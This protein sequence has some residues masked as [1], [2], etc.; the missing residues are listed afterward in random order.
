V[1]WQLKGL[2][3][4]SEFIKLWIGQTVSN[5]GSGITGVALPLT[6]V[7]YLA[8]TPAQMGI[9]SALSDVPVIV[10]GLLAGVWVDRLRRRAILISADLGRAILFGSIPI[11]ALF[12]VLHLAHLYIVAFLAG[13]LTVFFNVADISYLPTLV[14][15]EELVEANSKLGISDSLAEISGPAVA[16]PLAQL[17]GAPFALAFDALSYLLSALSIGLIRFAEPQPLVEERQSL[18]RESLKGLRFLFGNSLLRTLAISASIFNFFGSFIGT[19]YILYIVRE[20]HITPAII[21][22]L[23]ATGGV[24]AL[25]GTFIAQRVIRRIGP[26]RSIGVMLFLYGMTGL[27]TPLA[28]GPV[29][30]AAIMLFAAQLGDASVA[31]YFIAEISLRQSLIPNDLSGRLHAGMQFLTQGSRPISAIL[32][33]ILGTLIGLRLTILIGVVGVI[34]AGLWLLLSPIRRVSSL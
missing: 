4:N 34:C 30:L 15:Q 12:G 25:V 13:V 19:L 10:F 2:W 31:I 16:G 27:L 7:I 22:L 29:M 32:A 24:S 28:H 3:H 20:L 1:K 5:M 21:G 17:V 18:W 26:G 11:A 6:A 9:L 8:A 14:R 33:G 23:I